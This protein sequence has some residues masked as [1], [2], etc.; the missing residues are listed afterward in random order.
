MKKLISLL[1]VL[2][3]LCSISTAAFAAN[4][5]I[6]VTDGVK[7]HDTDVASINTAHTDL[8]LQVAANGQIDVTVPLNIVFKTNIDGGAAMEPTNYGITNNNNAPVKVTSVEV[9]VDHTNR[10]VMTLV[11][12]TTDT[13]DNKTLY[14]FEKDDQYMVKFYP[15][16]VVDG[17]D[18]YNTA[19]VNFDLDAAPDRVTINADDDNKTEIDVEMATSP[20]TFVTK[21]DTSYGLKLLTVKYTVALD[22]TEQVGTEI[23]DYPTDFEE[24]KD[25]EWNTDSNSW[26]MAEVYTNP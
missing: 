14:D 2:M 5:S 24:G 8:W 4:T 20:L 25:N 10:T 3:M 12:Y 13:V 16:S 11:P 1:L 15:E 23:E 18:L 6:G 17:F 21:T 26:T 7:Y 19:G 9:D 22:A